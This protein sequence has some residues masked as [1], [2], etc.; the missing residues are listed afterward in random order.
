MSTDA[1]LMTHLRRLSLFG[2][3][4]ADKLMAYIEELTADRDRLKEAL[5]SIQPFVTIGYA[6]TG[7][8]GSAEDRN[9]ALDAARAKMEHAL[10]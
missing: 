7:R 10:K 3:E 5:T 1:E 4:Q 6:P 8:H 9:A 2:D